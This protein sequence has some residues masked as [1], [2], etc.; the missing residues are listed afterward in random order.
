[1]ND[2]FDDFDLDS[3]DF[4]LGDDTFTFD[5]E[6]GDDQADT[7]SFDE[8][9]I[10]DT[11][12]SLD[13]DLEISDDDATEVSF[14]D[15]ELKVTDESEQEGNRRFLY[16]IGGLGALLVLQLIIL[17]GLSLIPSGPSPQ[18]FTATYIVQLNQTTEFQRTQT[19]VAIANFERLTQI[20]LS[21]TATPTPTFTR[22]PTLTPTFTTTP[23][24]ATDQALTSIPMT[25]TA[26]ALEATVF[27]L[28]QTS[29]AQTLTA[30]PTP[31]AMGL[32][33]EEI[34]MTSTALALLFEN[35]TQTLESTVVAQG[36]EGTSIPSTSSEPELPDSGFFDEVTPGG[37][38]GTITLAAFSL[39]GVIMFS[40]KLR[41]DK[42][43]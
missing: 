5:V 10:E 42:E 27:V 33:E 19:Q 23:I 14:G 34:G 11:D 17:L 39:I 9:A 32:A 40:R 20:A 38:L 31:T 21:A 3:D 16:I 4:D 1:M 43:E 41:L 13:D 25:L 36:V 26:T 15:D 24:D 29:V 18:A 12:F 22:P 28:E 35:L 6:G 30:Q 7:F 37:G 2:D 8:S